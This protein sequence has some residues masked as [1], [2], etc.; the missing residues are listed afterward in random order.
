M[1][2]VALIGNTSVRKI[3]NQLMDELDG[4][5]GLTALEDVTLL[6]LGTLVEQVLAV[7]DCQSMSVTAKTRCVTQAARGIHKL[8]SM[9]HF[10]HG[11]K[12]ADIE[13]LIAAARQHTR[14]RKKL[15]G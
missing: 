14:R 13:T 11:R 5:S 1:K 12:P 8:I 3:I 10:P 4:G 9:L 6:T 7:R 15:T 2:A